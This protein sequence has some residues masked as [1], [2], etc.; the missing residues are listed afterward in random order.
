M[1]LAVAAGNSWRIY[2]LGCRPETRQFN[3]STLS[4]LIFWKPSL[5]SRSASSFFTLD[6]FDTLSC[7]KEFVK[8]WWWNRTSAPNDDLTGCHRERRLLTQTLFCIK[9][10]EKEG[11]N[12]QKEIGQFVTIHDCSLS[13]AWVCQCRG[14]LASIIGFSFI[15][16][17]P[18]FRLP[19]R[20]RILHNTGDG[21]RDGFDTGDL[22]F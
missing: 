16:F 15:I 7:I 19:V 6:S 17:F 21:S 2:D 8:R 12:V 11:A 1:S 20:R 13:C 4:E 3:N 22:Y 10:I 9:W 18:V 14:P 5:G